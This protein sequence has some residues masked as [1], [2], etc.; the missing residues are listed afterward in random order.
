MTPRVQWVRYVRST[1]RIVQMDNGLEADYQ[2][3]ATVLPPELALLRV[4]TS[5]TMG[6][7]LADMFVDV[8]VDTPELARDA[9]KV[10]TPRAQRVREFYGTPQTRAVTRTPGWVNLPKT[11]PRRAESV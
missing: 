4:G 10:N 3:T 2:A 11:R 5:L 1:G 6:E 8:T 7:V 9:D